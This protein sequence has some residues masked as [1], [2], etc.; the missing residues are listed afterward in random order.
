VF[1]SVARR[2]NAIGFQFHPERSGYSGLKLLDIF[3]N[4]MEA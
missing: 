1:T 4:E 3:L 2:E